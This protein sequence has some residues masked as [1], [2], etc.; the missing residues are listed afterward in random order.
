MSNDT[1]PGS[2]INVSMGDGNHVNHIGHV[3]HGQSPKPL[4]NAIMQN[5]KEVGTVSDLAQETSSTIEVGALFYSDDF[6]PNAPFYL[7]GRPSV[8]LQIVRHPAATGSIS[9]LT[10][11]PVKKFMGVLLNK[12]ARQI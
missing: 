8:W 10:A 9:G 2:P 1:L 6:N 11:V 4:P 12:S 3:Y 5:D 7:Y